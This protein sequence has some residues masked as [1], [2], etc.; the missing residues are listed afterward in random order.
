MQMRQ[1][2]IQSPQDP[3]HPHPEGFR[4]CGRGIEEGSHILSGQSFRIRSLVLS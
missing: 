4:G 3:R 1:Q 2:W